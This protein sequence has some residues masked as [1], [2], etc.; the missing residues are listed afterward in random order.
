MLSHITL[1]KDSLMIILT[2]IPSACRPE[3]MKKKL[4]GFY[5][6][7]YSK[8][9]LILITV[10]YLIGFYTTDSL[11]HSK[12]NWALTISLRDRDSK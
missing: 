2:R 10:L 3:K 9:V 7:I 6:F 11:N 1:T 12:N 4:H 8:G 5:V